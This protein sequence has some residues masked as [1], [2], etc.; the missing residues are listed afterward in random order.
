MDNK[1]DNISP[2]E[3]AEKNFCFICSVELLCNDDSIFIC[4]NCFNGKYV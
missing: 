3:A 4:R 2:S 1:E